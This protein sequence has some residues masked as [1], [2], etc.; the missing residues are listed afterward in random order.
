MSL[1]YSIHLCFHF[2]GDPVA[3]TSLLEISG[4]DPLLQFGGDFNE[5]LNLTS[6]I[7]V[8]GAVSTSNGLYICEVCLFRGTQFEECHFANTSLQ[9]IGGPPIL[10]V[11]IDNSKHHTHLYY[12]LYVTRWVQLRPFSTLSSVLVMA[13]YNCVV[14]E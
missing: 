8:P 14:S 4:E 9:V 1:L 7:L 6:T 13:L 3:G 11:A 2:L 10:D 5:W 12:I